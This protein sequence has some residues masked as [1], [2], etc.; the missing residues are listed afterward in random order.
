MESSPIQAL[1]RDIH[2]RHRKNHDGHVASYIPELTHAK[3]HW[4]G[5]AVATRDGH[6]YEVGDTRQAF[7]IQSVSKALVYGLALEDNGEE[8]VLS[9]VG[10]EPSGEAF[11]A[12]S[13]R[14]KTGQPFNPMINAGAIATAG[15]VQPRDGQS[16]TERILQY[17]S[18][19][20]GRTLDIDE[21]VYHSESSTGHRNRAI[22]WMLRNFGILEEDPQ[23]ALETYFR[24]C[25]V[26]VTC[27]DLA[28]MAA[29]LANHGRNP[30]TRERAIADDCVD[31][32]LSVMATCGMYDA[33]GEW[34]YRVG[35][36]AKSG[37]GGGILAVLPGQLGIGVFSPLLDAQGNSV[38]GVAACV[39]LARELSLHLFNPSAAPQPSIRRTYDGSQVTS[40]RR[41]P[42]AAAHALRTYGSRIRLLELQGELLFSTVEPAVRAILRNA[43]YARHIVLDL[44][45]VVSLD[46]VSLRLLLG[47]RSSLLER[48]QP[49]RLA[50]CRC[51]G[52]EKAL[53][54]AGVPLEDIHLDADAAL[55]RAE[56]LLL[57]ELAGDK[58]FISPGNGLAGCMLFDGCSADDLAYLD[59]HLGSRQFAAGERVIES[60]APAD[61]LFVIVDGAV[62]VRVGAEIS[63][64]GNRV[65]VF[66]QGMTFG[67]MAFLDGAPRSADVIAIEPTSCRVL[68]RA[69]FDSMDSGHPGLKIR[70]LTRLARLLSAHL[71]HMNAEL[72]ALRD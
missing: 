50:F 70:I 14:A 43:P 60:G 32:I 62:E 58:A 19:C 27:R 10:V 46:D 51:S 63:A 25:S 56:N 53:H 29:T 47:T 37:V 23:D 20:A 61:E 7:T 65:D 17:L 31:N 21:A 59:Q 6:V 15:L 45:N 24:Q 28:L 1:L 35:L 8:R 72:N 3:P 18:R 44:R 71:R 49:V 12:I 39:D 38:R 41:R 11:N 69:L 34:V 67:E 64:P 42:H 26:R 66:T 4:F 2:E 9:K 48:D 36:P 13:L 30:L 22:G 57:A 54:A 33:S 68:D 16:R 5:L 52:H 40:R 55:E